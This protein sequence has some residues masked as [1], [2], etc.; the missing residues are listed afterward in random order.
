MLQVLPIATFG[1]LPKWVTLPLETKLV[2]AVV[3]LRRPQP[4]P[5]LAARIANAMFGHSPFIRQAIF[6]DDDVEPYD[7]FTAMTDRIYK[8]R[9]ENIIVQTWPKNIGLTENHDFKSGLTTCAYFDATWR[10]DR[11]EETIPRRVLF[12][13][14]YPD[15]MKEKVKK[16]WNEEFKLS[17]KA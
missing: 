9:P 16:A 3:S 14:M 4:F 6:V 17:P 13:V 8:T 15:E 1:I 7:L 10:L 5:G 11:P 12:E 2:L